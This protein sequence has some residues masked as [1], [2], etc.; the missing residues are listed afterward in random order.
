MHKT[1][2]LLFL[3]LQAS[4][5]RAQN[6]IQGSVLDAA[7]NMPLPSVT[8]RS[9]G[10]KL[11]AISQQGGTFKIQLL[12]LPDTLFF[13][14][15][16]YQPEF[17]IINNTTALGSILLRPLAAQ[18]EEVTINSGYQLI[19]RNNTTGSFNTISNKLLNDRPSTGILE[20]LEGI[21]SSYRVDRRPGAE[22]AI[23][24]RG[25]SSLYENTTGPLIIVDNFPYEEDINNINPNDV[26]SI[27]L[28][29]DAAAASIWGA[30]AGNGVIVIT[31][32]SGRYNQPLQLT[33][34]ANIR[35]T[36]KPDL[37]AIPDMSVQEVI[38]VETFL[39]NNNYYNSTLN[40]I[41]NHPPVTPMVQLLQARRN[42]TIS[43]SQFDQKVA[44]L[45]ANDRRT[46]ISNYL[47]RPASYTQHN[48]NLNWG[49]GKTKFYNSFGF[50]NNLENLVGN[51]YRRL[52]LKTDLTTALSKKLQ[53]STGILFTN[54]FTQ[55]NSP[56][57][58]NSFTVGAWA[59]PVY[60]RLADD[61]G[62]P[63]PVD[64]AYRS[65]F[66]DT[67]GNG[68]LLDW[69]YRPLQELQNADKTA[70]SNTFT[71][72]AGIKYSI[73]RALNVE[74][75]F[76]LQN[77]YTEHNDYRNTNMFYTRDLVN[78]FTQISAGTPKYA[79]P[80]DGILD[81]S[82]TH[83]LTRA[84]RTQLNYAKAVNPGHMISILAAAEIRETKT[85]AEDYRTYGF[86][87][88]NSTS[89]RVDYINYFPTYANVS[90]SLTIP[91]QDQ[92]RQSVLRFVSILSNASY[93]YHAKYTLSLSARKDAANIFGVTTNQKGTPLWS[94]GALWKIS[95]EPFY[96]SKYLSRLSLRTSYGYAGSFSPEVPAKTILQYFPPNFTI[97]NIPVASV[98][99]GANPSLRWQ[100]VGTFNIGID[101]STVGERFS[102]SF[103]W[104]QK[105][106]ID[107][108]ST[109][110]L[111]PTTGFSNQTTNS[112]DMTG[113]G[114]DLELNAKLLRKKISW[115]TTLLCSYVRNRIAGLKAIT[116][117]IASLY[118]GNALTLQ[119]RL[120]LEPFS[121]LAY[122]WGGLNNKGMPQGYWNDTLTTDYSLL[123]KTP[124]AKLINKGLAIP[125]LFGS[126]RNEWAYRNWSL[127][128]NVIFRFGYWFNKQSI[129][130]AN[131]YQR[132]DTHPDYAKRWQKPG[133][134]KYTNVPAMIYPVPNGMDSYYQY[135]EINVLRADN[136]KL[137]WFTLSYNLAGAAKSRLPFANTRLYLNANN[138]NIM[139]WKANKEG[140]D[141]DYRRTLITPPSYSL[142]CSITLK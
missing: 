1:C 110:G 138:L 136:I 14:H 16:G 67:A 73:S 71:I 31:T 64:M 76:Q 27:T 37:F 86:N 102:G 122:R 139:L 51:K 113:K 57:T 91:Y 133:D 120:G 19:A 88:R 55:N 98:V 74:S 121:I 72:N 40:N 38:E 43:A 50:D 80:N 39:F 35:Y 119:P 13:S 106:T 17:R 63:L 48:V 142:G 28:L 118:V 95:D 84:A 90:G 99:A 36:P 79:V 96:K 128:C 24:I 123:A 5:A 21:T 107:L 100:K 68:K 130:Y 75:R 41:T 78:T 112:A 124:S 6:T 26:E 44:G 49:V 3:C 83:T 87:N 25:L 7:T 56:G 101:F 89:T 105:N 61:Q 126:L 108:L 131:L 92:F 103:E 9:A 15:T 132:L 2:L 33:Y 62:N 23:Q 60:S 66:T 8:I 77:G 117:D 22:A 97:I 53:L 129:G 11:Q 20:K 18:L 52:T 45:L 140:I 46:D 93:T 81:R 29:K 32:K 94:A 104:F 10:N 116:S 82:Y 58:Y 134:E 115:N 54:Q 127:A 65:Q 114:F 34:N 85:N 111:D 30:R 69:K 125:P 4:L 47:Y 42:G 70:R 59:L 109:Q 137:D 12:T 135:A 141:P